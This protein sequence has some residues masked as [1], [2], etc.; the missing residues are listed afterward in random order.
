MLLLVVCGLSPLLLLL[1]R[2]HL[3]FWTLLLLNHALSLVLCLLVVAQPLIRIAVGCSRLERLSLKWCF[4]ISDLGVD[5]LC[6]KCFYLKVLDVSYLK[7][8]IGSWEELLWKVAEL[9]E[10]WDALLEPTY[11]FTHQGRRWQSHRIHGVNRKT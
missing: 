7:G 6:K 2:H 10:G 8:S 3:P 1:S 9:Q 5:L 4:E 11:N